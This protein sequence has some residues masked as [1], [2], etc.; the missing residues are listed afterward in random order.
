MTSPHPRSGGRLPHVQAIRKGDRVYLYYRRD[1][2]RTPLP[3]PEG[4]AAFLAAYDRIHALHEAGPKRERPDDGTVEA[5]IAAYLGGADFQQLAPATQR[6]YRHSLE[7]FRAKFGPL[8]LAN[9]DPPWWEALRAKYGARPADWN[10]LKSHMQLVIAHYRRL[11]PKA[12]P[13]SPLAEVKRLRVKGKS[14]QNRPWPRGVLL[15]VL[16]EATPEFRALLFCYLL[17]AQ[18]GG[19][20]TSMRP[21]AYNEDARTLSFVQ[22]KTDKP[23]VLHV[24]DALAA[25]FAAMKGRREDVLLATP[26]GE[27]WTLSNAQEMLRRMLRRLGLPRYTLHGLRATGPTALTMAGVSSPTGRSLTGH[28]SDAQYEV[29]TRG[30]IGY[31][32]ARE[33]A[34]QLVTIFG[35]ILSEAEA[36]GNRT[37]ASGVTGRAAAKAKME[38]DERTTSQVSATASAP[39]ARQNSRKRSAMA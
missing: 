12:L 8:K 32:L 20:V 17:T 4:S 33:A 6:H 21:A 27:A 19:D 14:D 9:L 25:A 24:P 26:R 10:R 38:A 28:E 16:R 34:E 15:A 18:R 3:S 7:P 5:A 13:V 29:Y 2:K 37:K 22:S 35:G 39:G 36:S 23:M 1:E 30:A 31:D 11:N